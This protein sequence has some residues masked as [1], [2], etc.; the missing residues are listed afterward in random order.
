M[1]VH[2]TH[3]DWGYTTHGSQIEEL[4]CK[5]IG[6]AV[7]LCRQ[8]ASNDEMRR[9]RWTC[10][11]ALIVER[12]LKSSDPKQRNQFLELVNQGLIEVTAAPLTPFPHC[13][14]KTIDVSM[15]TV[16]RLGK[17]YGIKPKVAMFADINGLSWIWTDELIKTGVKYLSMAMNYFC[18]AGM[19]RYTPFFWV[20]PKGKKLLTWHG[21]HYNA[22]AYWGLN[23]YDFDME[24]VV[25]Q[26]LEEIAE[27]PY[28]K[29]LL[30]VTNIPSDNVGPHPKMFDFIDKYNRLADAKNWPVM[31]MATLTEWF[32]Y[33]EKQGGNKTFPD[34]KGDWSDWWASALATMPIEIA[35]LREAY[36]KVDLAD[37]WL[38]KL[39]RLDTKKADI[40]SD[41]I[42]DLRNQLFLICEHVIG[43][44]EAVKRPYSFAARA[45][46]SYKRDKIY[47]SLYSV[48]GLLEQIIGA[49]R[50]TKNSSDR[51][52]NNKLE[53][54]DPNW[55][56]LPKSKIANVSKEFKQFSK[57]NWKYISNDSI[58]LG[59]N[60]DLGAW[61]LKLID[62]KSKELCGKSQ[63]GKFGEV[64][65]EY[66]ADN[67]R[68]TWFDAS[69]GYSAKMQLQTNN[70][71][72]NAKW[73]RCALRPY[74]EKKQNSVKKS[75][76]SS[77]LSLSL[78]GGNDNQ[79]QA[80]VQMSLDSHL[81]IVNM[82]YSIKMPVS[83]EPKSLYILFP[84]TLKPTELKA[85]IGGTWIKP[86]DEQLPNS[87]LNWL[88]V[89]DGVLVNDK[90]NG[91][92]AL[93]TPLD[94]PL[95]MFETICPN[96]PKQPKAIKNAH[97]VSWA[98]HNYWT[99]NCGAELG[100]EYCFRY[101]LSFWKDTI[102]G[103]ALEQYSFAQSSHIMK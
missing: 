66:P 93:W 7:D 21:N 46:E 42:Y 38:T 1:L 24:E 97:L 49:C 40:F 27:F 62:D 94:A 89:F 12:Y 92:S 28:E 77:V 10:E 50:G 95:V 57:N 65:I 86:I 74:A 14:Q 53:T 58:C 34:L 96:P 67:S 23:H 51:V 98:A 76:N 18:G 6:Q 103:K 70:W 8:N 71:P 5:I 59:L 43:S 64:V 20:S 16:R 56:R 39:K 30:Q 52:F 41:K 45:G 29:F 22:G 48:N 99:T 63:D 73:T 15:D 61:S 69:R 91:Y 19:P 83:C 47:S 9:F 60:A 44:S 101:R 87:C 54:Y 32:Q 80:V 13:D 17:D 100:G 33:L 75:D 35:A 85:N 82:C 55:G 3:T 81:P 11:S 68:N 31:R 37:K 84:L 102:D 90:I 4:H 78:K 2:H 36:R 72:K 25:P 79:V 88:T 26:R